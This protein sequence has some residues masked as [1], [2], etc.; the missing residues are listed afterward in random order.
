MSRKHLQEIRADYEHQLK[1]QKEEYDKL[2]QQLLQVRQ[3]GISSPH[4]EELRSTTLSHN[5]F[6]SQKVI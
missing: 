6:P 4:S 5:S 3:Q 2:E 1:S